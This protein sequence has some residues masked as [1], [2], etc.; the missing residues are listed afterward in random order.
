MDVSLIIAV[1][2]AIHAWNTRSLRSG[3][4]PDL[5]LPALSSLTVPETRGVGVIYFFAP[6]C[7]YCKNSIDNLE[8]LVT[9]GRVGWARA[10]AL[11]YESLEDI[12]EFVGDTGFTQPV[13]L[14]S[15]DVA[16]QWGI[17]AFPTY[18]VIDADGEIASRS[19]G[20]STK[21]GLWMRAKLAE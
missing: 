7:I 21:A 10:V 14:G 20:Y 15:R 17:R 12:H 19:V 9:S 4:L 2:L 18:F 5:D 13:L 11:E 8:S 1:F 3:A 16:R 6:W